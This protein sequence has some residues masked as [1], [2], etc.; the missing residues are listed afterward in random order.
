MQDTT[1]IA[2]RQEDVAMFNAMLVQDIIG[3]IKFKECSRLEDLED[4][5]ELLISATK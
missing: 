5:T 3:D 1:D 4:G 2:S